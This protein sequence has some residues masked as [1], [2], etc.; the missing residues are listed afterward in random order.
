MTQERN[1]NTLEHIVVIVLI[2][3]LIALIPT[4]VLYKIL[5]SSALLEGAKYGLKIKMGGAAAFFMFFFIVFFKIVE[6][7]YNM[8]KRRD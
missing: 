3:A 5:D 7:L 8:A 6:K 1:T 2:A 4:F